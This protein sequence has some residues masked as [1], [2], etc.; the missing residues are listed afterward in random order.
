MVLAM[1]PA[2]VLETDRM[3]ESASVLVMASG[4]VPAT[5]QM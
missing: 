1:T 2:T 4:R 3:L 5:E